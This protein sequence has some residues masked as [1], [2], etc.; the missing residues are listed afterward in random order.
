MVM[1]THKKLQLLSDA[2]QYD[3]SCACG[4]NSQDRRKRGSDGAWLYPVSIP[5]GGSAIMLK[6]LMSNVCVNDC[7]Y[8][9]YRE[10][11]DTPRC[12][13]GPDDMAS[14]FLDYERKMNLIGLFLSSGVIKNPDMS[15]QLLNDTAR[16]LRKKHN[17]KG[18]IHLKIIPGASDAAIDDALSLATTVSLNIETPG[19]LRFKTLS[20]KKNYLNDIIKPMQR[21]SLM[22]SKG[23]QF[24]KVGKTTQFIVGAS[25][26][27]DAEIVKY[28]AGLYKK[29]SFDR[30]YFSAYQK[31]LGDRGIPGENAF[32]NPEHAFT[33]EHRLYQVDFLLRQYSF[34]EN[35]ICFTGNGSLSMDID[36][37][38]MWA[39]RHPEYYPVCI[40]RASKTELMKVPGIGPLT[41]T[42]IVKM[43]KVSRIDSLDKLPLSGKRKLC[44]M[45]YI[46]L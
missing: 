8:C 19:E 25:D 3:L 18:Y 40:N 33:R 34:T 44:A 7:A 45:Q 29:L 16:I 32:G 36:P 20:S 9:P 5:S 17:Y 31:G 30:V 35:D 2:S 4:T 10:M 11:T 23:A 26:E 24:E 37:K 13:I 38:M 41:A 1:D 27:T 43:R 21:I 12:T 6:T 28:T 15:M 46:A 22:T 14:L 39:Q 42:R